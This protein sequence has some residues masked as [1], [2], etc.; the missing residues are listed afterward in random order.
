MLRKLGARWILPLLQTALFVFGVVWGSHQYNK[1]WERRM[2]LSESAPPTPF[3]MKLAVIMNLPSFIPA[4]GTI[5][6]ARALG[7]RR[8]T[9]DPVAI[10]VFSTWVG[11][12]W[13]FCGRWLDCQLGHIRRGRRFGAVAYWAII[14]VCTLGLGFAIVRNMY[15]VRLMR[16]DDFVEWAIGAWSLIVAICASYSFWRPP[17]IP[18]QGHSS[19][20]ANA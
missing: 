2:P 13:F 14:T 15:S 6:I 11:V 9:S 16:T 4:A 17:R 20:Q 7:I 1:G 5:L 10:P 8:A 12:F 3:I 18:S 19:Q